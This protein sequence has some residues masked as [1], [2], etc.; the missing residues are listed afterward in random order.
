[1]GL[2]AYQ[3]QQRYL[4]FSTVIK[5]HVT[6]H[7]AY[8]YVDFETKWHYRRCGHL[9]IHIKHCFSTMY[10]LLKVHFVMRYTKAVVCQ[11]C[12]SV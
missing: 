2:L 12:A 10:I 6:A 5:D 4:S 8:A 3:R 11:R 7:E 9:T 1:M